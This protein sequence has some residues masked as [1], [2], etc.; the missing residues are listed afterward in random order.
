MC[1]TIAKLYYKGNYILKERGTNQREIFTGEKEYDSTTDSGL[2][3]PSDT[4]RK[5]LNAA[6]HSFRANASSF[7]VSTALRFKLVKKMIHATNPPP[8]HTHTQNYHIIVFSKESVILTY[9]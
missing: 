6:G 8:P 5:V 1:A 4:T 2:F 9:M 7:V 3:T